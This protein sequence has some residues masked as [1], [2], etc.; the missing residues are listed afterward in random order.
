MALNFPNSPTQG[1]IHNASNGLKYYFD[2]VKWISQGTFSTGVIHAEKLDNIASGFNGSLKTFNLQVNGTTIKP[3]NNQAV[4]ISVNNV[5]LE[6]TVA[7]QINVNTGQITFTAAPTNGHA[8]FGVV[9]SRIP[10]VN[11]VSN[12]IQLSNGDKG[13]I[14]ITHAGQ[15]NEAYTIDANAITTAKI[16]DDAV[17]S[18]KIADNAITSAH[19]ADGTVIAADIAA[20]AIGASELAD[21]AVDTAAIAAD[22]VTQNTM[23]MGL[24]I[25][26]TLL[27]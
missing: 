1:D 23:L 26:L 3:P 6:P 14:T 21:N 12:P 13:D 22:A 17:T 24:L 4:L 11:A 18:A 16:A 7:Y 19:I 20:N 25:L 5:I 10:L 8:F 15:T 27:T 2:G 9:Y